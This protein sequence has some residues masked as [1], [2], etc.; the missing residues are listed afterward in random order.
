MTD[1]P[2]ARSAPTIGIGLTKIDGRN[3]NYEILTKGERK[4]KLKIKTENG[5]NGR[6][7]LA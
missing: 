2:V 1:L 5:E 4:R 6:K 3:Y 7:Y